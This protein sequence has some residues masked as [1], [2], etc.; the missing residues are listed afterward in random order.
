MAR[1]VGKTFE[2]NFK[3]SIPDYVLSY[4]PP[5]SAQGFDVGASNKLRFSR[6]SPCDLMI[7]D[8]TRNLFLTLELKTFQGSCSF[9][10]TKE[11][12]GIIHHYQIKSLKDFAQYERVISGLVL[13]F[14]STGN[15]YFLN[16]NQWDEF[17]SHIE[18][19][20]FNEKDLLAYADPIL[21]EKRKLKVNYRYDIESFLKILNI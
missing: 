8:G 6:H 2:D 10:R 13:D 18:K 12:K 5:D 11:E 14:R 19:K 17:I 15:T 4:R 3:K 16:I 21:I 1:S 9:E 7:F 20:S